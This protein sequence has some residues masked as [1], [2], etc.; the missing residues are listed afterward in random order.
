MDVEFEDN[1]NST[2]NINDDVD[3][4]KTFINAGKT[5]SITVNA[6]DRVSLGHY[7]GSKDGVDTFTAG[8]YFSMNNHLKTEGGDD[9]IRIG[10]NADLDEI[11]GGKGFDVIYTQTDPD[12]FKIKKIEEISIVCFAAG[13]LISTASG[14]IAI[15]DLKV[16]DMV[17]TLDHGE[18]P[19]RWIGSRTL[20]LAELT[21]KP[22]L[23]PIRIS[24]GALGGGLPTRDLVVSPQH[25]VLI[26]LAIAKRIF[27]VPEV[28]IPVNKLVGI[29]GINVIENRTEIMYF[30]LLFD[31]HQLVFSEGAA[32]ESLYLGP[33]GDCGPRT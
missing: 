9:V 22:K 10:A 17:T 5:E 2:V 31:R 4:S 18:Q 8:D 7:H 29:E 11:D 33:Q 25:R 14:L 1:L 3:L 19:I 12:D 27:D 28:L 30:H 24:A 20:G 32:T 23:K 21:A 26:R 15:E 13:T 16:G 6:G